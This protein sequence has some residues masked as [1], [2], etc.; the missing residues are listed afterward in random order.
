MNWEA[1]AALA[2]GLALPAIVA[3]WLLR[4]RRPRLRVPS[5]FLWPGSPAQPTVGGEA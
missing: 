5:L 1:P 3:L 2:L 4:P